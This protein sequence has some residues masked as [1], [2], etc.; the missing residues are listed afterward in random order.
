MKARQAEE[1]TGRNERGGRI[2]SAGAAATLFSALAAAQDDARFTPLGD[3]A[4]GKDDSLAT[5]VS[6]DG[7]TVVGFAGSAA[8][9]G[10]GGWEAFR[11][12]E[13]AGI[14]PLGDLPGAYYESSAYGISSDG[15]TIVGNSSQQG[16]GDA[17]PEYH[18][19]SY[20]DPTMTNLGDW[21]FQPSAELTAVDASGDGSVVVGRVLWGPNWE[22]AA[23]R[24]DAAGYQDL[25]TLPG[26][27][28]AHSMAVSDDG[29]TVTGYLH[30]GAFTSEGFQ[31]TAALGM[32]G[33]G[34]G[35]RALGA[36]SDGSIVVGRAP[37]TDAFGRWTAATGWV[38]LGGGAATAVSD[39]GGVIV[40]T[41]S[42]AGGSDAHFWTP[43]GG[44]QDLEVA[45]EQHY[46]VDLTGW[47]L[48]AVD[49][50]SPDGTW[51]VGH[52]TNPSGDTEAFRVYLP[53]TR[54]ATLGHALAGSNGEAR[55]YGRGS[56]L[57]GTQTDLV[58]ENALPGALGVL[59]IGL[60]RLDAPFAGGT[61]VPALD[62]LIPGVVVSGAGAAS[63]GATWPEG[64]PSGFTAWFQFW[65]LDLANPKNFAATNALS[66]TAP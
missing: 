60:D 35:S 15:V 27:V 31:W 13:A 6:A 11:W 33:L 48:S 32:V 36:S 44:F 49:D 34:A 61:M 29:G 40:G 18:A 59:V 55:M 42:Y 53:R 30:D 37:Q 16:I 28:S 3:L 26:Y 25:G 46:G 58:I 10:I 65:F 7:A 39:D 2:A 57:G 4:G 52:A 54:W 56:L 9:N 8:A 63:F 50:V 38:T 20:V 23:F 64:V 17:Y 12:T 21:P 14:V 51:L 1:R 5:A 66:C 62:I 43:E 19:F 47:N 45:L 22:T 24:L 41:N